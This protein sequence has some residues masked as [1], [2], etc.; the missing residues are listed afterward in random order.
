MLRTAEQGEEGGVRVLPQLSM[1]SI[2]G[3]M[4]GVVGDTWTLAYPLLPV[5]MRSGQPHDGGAP[6]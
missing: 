1:R 6:G 4:F 3:R 2:R 5:R